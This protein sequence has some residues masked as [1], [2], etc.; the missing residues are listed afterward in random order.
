MSSDG[1]T[2][3]DSSA[4]RENQA[5]SGAASS[6][7][8]AS[9][10]QA[11]IG[12]TD[13]SDTTV[14]RFPGD[15]SPQATIVVSPTGDGDYATIQ[16]AIDFAPAEARILIRPGRY[17]ESVVI[18]KPVQLDADSESGEV[19]LVAADGPCITVDTHHATVSHLACQGMSEACPARTVHTVH[20][21]QG[22][23]VLD[24]CHLSASSG[25][26]LAGIGPG[27]VPVVQG[28]SF[29][30]GEV[31]FLADNGAQGTL[32]GVTIRGAALAGVLISNGSDAAFHNCDICE[33]K[34]SGI[35]AFGGCQGRFEGCR[36]HNHQAACVEI[37]GGSQSAFI[38]CAIHDGAHL[39]VHVC[40][41][42]QPLFEHCDIHSH[43]KA[44]V[45]VSEK[46][47]PVFRD[48]TIRDGNASGVFAFAQAA[49]ALERC[50]IRGH[51]LDGIRIAEDS[52]LTLDACRILGG[53]GR[54]AYLYAG[55][56]GT[57]ND[58][59]V[60]SNAKHGL[61]VSDAHLALRG[62]SVSC[63]GGSGVVIQGAGAGTLERCD[64]TGNQQSGIEADPGCNLNV[65]DCQQ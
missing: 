23:L 42:A 8:A 53:Q 65:S 55:G 43:A 28:G 4:G 17:T 51:R 3:G 33:G 14:S 40:K 22:R 64:L 61:L 20:L 15:A 52:S 5:G 57:F 39:G 63:N 58:C 30:N 41:D 25:A 19:V 60:R 11:A 35:V 1:T 7:G 36:I 45:A 26:C 38:R 47:R 29:E 62:C 59:D 10:L 9:P 13:G 50:E 27:A 2:P 21:R 54:G 56:R 44:C 48:C 12:L 31:G 32:D 37:S 46:A 16:E 34:A 49:A 18:D 6:G 24:A